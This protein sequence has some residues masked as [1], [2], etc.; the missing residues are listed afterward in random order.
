MNTSTAHAKTLTS[1]TSSNSI[2]SSWNHLQHV[3]GQISESEFYLVSSCAA[4]RYLRKLKENTLSSL[5]LGA[6]CLISCITM[7]F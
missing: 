1:L 7:V 3:T 5:K 4:N 2:K 6:V